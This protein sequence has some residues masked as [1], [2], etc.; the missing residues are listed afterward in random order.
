MICVATF[1]IGDKCSVVLCLKNRKY[2]GVSS[3]IQSV[4]DI[5]VSLVKYVFNCKPINGRTYVDSDGH[6]DSI[7]DLLGSSKIT[8]P[9]SREHNLLRLLTTSD[10]RG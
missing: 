1:C 6:V 7:K 3:L 9:Q 5:G 4:V 10:T 2:G 8:N